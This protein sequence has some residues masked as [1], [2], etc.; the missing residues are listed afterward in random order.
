MTEP[1]DKRKTGRT[2]S[3]EPSKTDDPFKSSLS[4]LEQQ[5]LIAEGKSSRLGIDG[6]A[7]LRKEMER[8]TKKQS[9]ASEQLAHPEDKERAAFEDP[10]RSASSANAFMG[11]ILPVVGRLITSA[12]IQSENLR[13]GSPKGGKTVGERAA[14]N[15]EASIK[16]DADLLANPATFN[17]SLDERAR[18][19]ADRA[20]LEPD[21]K[22]G[23]RPSIGTIKAYI[24]GHKSALRGSQKK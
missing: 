10:S 8:I 24:K 2:P 11:E 12:A 3:V 21:K 5:K 9:A 13:K 20:P 14:G 18:Y 22:N 16:C 4:K 1:T 17:W 23:K 19:I 6:V 15:R 7:R